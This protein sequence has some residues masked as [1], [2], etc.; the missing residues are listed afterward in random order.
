MSLNFRLHIPSAVTLEPKKIK[1]VTA[2]TFSPSINICQEVMELDAM[3]YLS[4]YLF[5]N[6]EF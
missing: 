3:I 2:G 5:L 1:S 6:V 4:L